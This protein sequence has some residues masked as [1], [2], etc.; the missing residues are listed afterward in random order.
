MPE[1]FLTPE[2]PKT[3]DVDRMRDL[4]RRR[5]MQFLLPFF[6]GWLII[7]TASWFMPVRYKSTTT[8]LVQ[9]PSVPQNYVTPN[10]SVNLQDRLASL[11]EQI[12]SRTRLL[13]L[14]FHPTIS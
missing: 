12:L 5:H 3:V 8:I 11:T 4:V 1:D 9:Q 7:W 13:T 10:I 14:R 6:L 2:Q